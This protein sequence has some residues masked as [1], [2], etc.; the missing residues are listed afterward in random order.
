MQSPAFVTPDKRKTTRY[1]DA[2]QQ[3]FRNMNMKTPEAY[4][5]QAREMFFTAHPD[6]QSALDEL[7]ESDAR[8][9]NLSLRQL[10]EWHAERIYAAFF[11]AEE[12][13]WND[14]FYSAR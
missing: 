5:A 6:F 12:S 9:A 1:T 2:L 3:T 14:L 11:A 7:T 4:Y 10:R 13:G 8:A